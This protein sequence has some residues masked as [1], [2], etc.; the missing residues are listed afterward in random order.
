MRRLGQNR[1]NARVRKIGLALCWALAAAIALGVF[2]AVL[3]WVTGW[4]FNL[5]LDGAHG[6]KDTLGRVIGAVIAAPVV[7]IAA[8]ATCA[9][10]IGAP[11]VALLRMMGVDDPL[12]RRARR[13][14]R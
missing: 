8:G 14:V 3:V 13:R 11:L 7:G 9:L 6:W 5:I 10:A 4:M 12:R 1:H 2:G